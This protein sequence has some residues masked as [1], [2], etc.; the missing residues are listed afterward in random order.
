MHACVTGPRRLATIGAAPDV[1]VRYAY[2]GYTCY[3]CSYR[4]Y[5][6]R[7]WPSRAASVP[8]GRLHHCRTRRQTWFRVRVWARV[9]VRVR[10]GDGDGGDGGEGGRGEGASGDGGEPFA[11]DTLAT[12]AVSP[13]EVTS[14]V[15]EARHYAVERDGVI[16]SRAWLADEAGYNTAERDGVIESGGGAIDSGAYLAHEARNH[17]VERAAGVMQRC[18]AAAAAAA[19]AW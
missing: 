10:G 14:L 18:A 11:V 17:A 6:G 19:L 2:Y 9:W 8:S 4:W 7:R 12:G 16:D 13:H 3:G 1:A 15:D 5:R